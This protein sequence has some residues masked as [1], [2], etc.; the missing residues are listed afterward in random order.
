MA[1]S[2]LNFS[3][4]QAEGWL[5]LLCLFRFFSHFED[6][7]LSEKCSVSLRNVESFELEET[8]KGHLVQL[9]CNEQ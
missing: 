3:V 2:K 7:S 6:P 5:L 1:L 8:F 4:L 9:P